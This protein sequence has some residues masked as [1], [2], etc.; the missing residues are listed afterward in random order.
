MKIGLFPLV[1]DLLH[2][3]HLHALEYAKQHCDY[4]IAALN[5]DPTVDNP[6]KQKPIE[7]IYER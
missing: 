5:V 1:G 3:G 2:T 6:N 7:T 4:L